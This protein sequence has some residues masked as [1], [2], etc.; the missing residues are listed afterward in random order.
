MTHRVARPD[1]LDRLLAMERAAG[2]RFLEV[3]IDDTAFAGM[4][5]GLMARAIDA[6]IFFVAVD[7]EDVPV[8]FALCERFEE[9]LHLHELGV[10]PD[11]QGQGIGR[12]LIDRVAAAARERGCSHVTLTT[13]RDVSF[14]G[15]FYRRYG[16]VELAEL[17]GWLTAIRAAEI[18]HGLDV[19]PRIAM[20]L[21]L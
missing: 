15:P 4:D 10:Q 13:Y 21:V 2:R 12:S 6:G 19:L 8:G 14:N 1:E 17:P 9:S 7:D 16:F 11:Q 20:A 18:R 5:R 3:G